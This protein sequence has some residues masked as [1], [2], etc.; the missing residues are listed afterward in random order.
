MYLVAMTDVSILFF[1]SATTAPCK[2]FRTLS[3]EADRDTTA[4]TIWKRRGKYD[5]V[6]TCLKH[7]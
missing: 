5:S 1:F 6:Q 7:T 3:G 2:S 4:C